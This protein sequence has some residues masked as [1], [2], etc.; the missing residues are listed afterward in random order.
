VSEALEIALPGW[1]PVDREDL[2]LRKKAVPLYP[3]DSTVITSEKGHKAMGIVCEI[4]GKGEKLLTHCGRPL[5]IPCMKKKS[6]RKRV[7]LSKALAMSV[8]SEMETFNR[9]HNRQDRLR[10]VTLTETTKPGH[11]K[12]GVTRLVKDFRKLCKSKAWMDEWGVRGILPDIEWTLTENG[13]HVHVHMALIGGFIPAGPD[14]ARPGEPNLRDIWQ[15]ITG[16]S[17]IVDVREIRDP[18]T[19]VSEVEKYLVK[20]ISDSNE[21]IQDWPLEVR[22]EVA[23]V[24]AGPHRIRWYC[25]THRSRSRKNCLDFIPRPGMKL[26]HPC[27]GEYRKER[28]GFRSLLPTGSFR[29]AFQEVDAETED[30][31]LCRRCGMAK[32]RGSQYWNQRDGP[33][34]AQIALNLIEAHEAGDTKEIKGL[35]GGDPMANMPSGWTPPPGFEGYD[36]K[37]ALTISSFLK[38]KPRSIEWIL[39]LCEQLDYNLTERIVQGQMRLGNWVDVNG[40]V[41]LSRGRTR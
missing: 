28:A 18:R 22:H 40:T 41:F 15:G 34:N 8:V 13:W 25:H 1:D 21:R 24:I 10:L 31:N 30:Q 27:D 12:N 36:P 32:M 35:C 9:A 11:L 39:D 23:E 4:C 26:K 3:L 16:D 19:V 37:I 2:E 29:K 14:F 17:F 33:A 6:G 7:R 20:P 38:E 5:C